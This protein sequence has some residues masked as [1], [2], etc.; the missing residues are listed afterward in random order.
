MPNKGEKSYL[1]L[2]LLGVTV[3]VTLW[4]SVFP[5]GFVAIA[6]NKYNEMWYKFDWKAFI[7]IYLIIAT[8][9]FAVV[10]AFGMGCDDNFEQAPRFCQIVFS[11]LFLLNGFGRLLEYSTFLNN[12]GLLSIFIALAIHSY[13]FMIL[14]NLLKYKLKPK[15]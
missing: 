6:Y 5:A 8:I 15:I 12:H 7:K 2:V 3:I 13:F 14:I 10:F 4:Q 11:T 1:L 9:S